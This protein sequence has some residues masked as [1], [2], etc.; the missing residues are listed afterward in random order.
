MVGQVGVVV[1]AVVGLRVGVH[2]RGREPGQRVDEA[3]LGLDRDTVSLH[4][5]QM[6]VDHDLALG[7]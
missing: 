3:M 2:E 5:G 7:P 6:R 4:K 1:G